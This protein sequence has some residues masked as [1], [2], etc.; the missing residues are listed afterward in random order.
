MQRIL[1]RIQYDGSGFNGY[2]KQLNGRTVQDALERALSV[3][4]K[5]DSWP[6]TSSGRTDTAVHGLNQAVHF[7]TPLSISME[8]WPMALN[9]VLPDD[10]QVLQ[11]MTV[12]AG[13]HARYD[14]VGKVYRYRIYNTAKRDVFRRHYAHH[15]KGNLDPVRIQK[16]AAHLEGTHD[17][18]S[19]TSAKT[20]V[21]D[22]VRTLFRVK[23]E[24]SGDDLNLIFAGSGFLYQMVRV[25]TGTLLKIGNGEWDPDII[26][27]IIARKDRIAAG[28]TAPGNGLYLEDVFY[29]EES[30]Q[31]Y[32]RELDEPAEG[33]M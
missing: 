4:H 16:A 10:V 6:C 26:P 1:I 7:D 27:E 14:T 3:I 17:F 11:A 19:L 28:P 9:S 8:R 30:L 22:K 18:T 5:T 23:V 24:K 25:L 15:F 29:D 12:P 33:R 13:F 32:L 20:E 31:A 21:V 2:Q